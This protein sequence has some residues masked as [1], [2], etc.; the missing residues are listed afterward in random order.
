MK[1]WIMIL[2][3]LLVS[4]SVAMA[5]GQV[6]SASTGTT[7]TSTS[8]TTTGGST[9]TV[10]GST[11]NS[12]GNLDPN[13][14]SG[15]TATTATGTLGSATVAP[16]TGITNTGIANTATTTNLTG[17]ISQSN[18]NTMF[19]QFVTANQ[20]GNLSRIQLNALFTQFR[21]VLLNPAGNGLITNPLTGQEINV[22]ANPFNTGLNLRGTGTAVPTGTG[23]LAVFPKGEFPNG[24][25]LNFPLNIHTSSGTVLINPNTNLTR[26]SGS[27]GFSSSTAASASDGVR[28]PTLTLL[29]NGQIVIDRTNETFISNGSDLMAVHTT[30]K[31]ILQRNNGTFTNIRSKR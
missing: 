6:G 15:T 22:F 7:S 16:T 4:F 27:T 3:I 31:G 24:V 1:Q 11:A 18:L 29:S 23:N 2:A 12:V 9:G 10:A 20:L 14:F 5:A 17:T 25:V 28:F 19:N 26:G 21:G 30:V 8:T 13:T